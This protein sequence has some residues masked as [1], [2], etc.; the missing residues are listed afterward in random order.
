MYQLLP[1]DG[2]NER[3]Y[4][5]SV[6]INV[7]RS[8]DYRLITA[9]DRVLE[10]VAGENREALLTG[11]R[12]YAGVG[13]DE[14]YR[15]QYE[16]EPGFLVTQPPALIRVDQLRDILRPDS[17]MG[18]TVPGRVSALQYVADLD[19][20]PAVSATER[21]QVLDALLGKAG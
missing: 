4:V 6:G 11:L 5:F 13:F 19:G 9:V 12:H 2:D 15:R 21:V 14:S 7:D 17:F 10:R 18:G 20:L 16:L 3:V 8:R 1:A